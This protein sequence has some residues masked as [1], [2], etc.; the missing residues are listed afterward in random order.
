MKQAKSLKIIDE[1]EGDGSEAKL[2]DI[3]HVWCSCR[4]K[5]G[6]ILF[7]SDSVGLYQ[8]RLGARDAFVALEQ[9]T[10]GMRKGGRRSVK[11]PPNI[12]YYERNVYPELSEK[13]VLYYNIQLME[14]TDQW[15]NTLH[16]RTS[17]IYSE[18]TKKLGKQFR[19]LTPSTEKESEFQKIQSKL[20][21]QA[22]EEYRKYMD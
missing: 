16:I 7:S 17:S 15:D 11:A 9:G 14:I 13:T 21:K 2:G 20:F 4:F 8:I 19:R 22:N 5:N 18:S 10:I 1:C 12:I 3:V 6:N